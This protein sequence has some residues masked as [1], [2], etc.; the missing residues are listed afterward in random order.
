METKLIR[1]AELAKTNP[2]MKF[3]S[4]THLINEESL[5]QCHHELP[6]GK[7]TG[8]ERVTKEEYAENLEENIADLVKR[9]KRNAY[10]PVPVRRTYI[11]KA[12]TRYTRNLETIPN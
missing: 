3:T 9:M 7:A 4:I 10:K 2:K 6:S 12:G 8:I 1:I 11:L 5:I